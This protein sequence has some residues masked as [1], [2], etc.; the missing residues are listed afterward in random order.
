MYISGGK[1]ARSSSKQKRYRARKER[2]EMNKKSCGRDEEKNE[3]H[4]TLMAHNANENV[5]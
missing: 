5:K 4:P 1:V 3:Y 2:K